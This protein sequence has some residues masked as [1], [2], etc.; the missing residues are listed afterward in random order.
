MDYT[1]EQE[2][3]FPWQVLVLAVE[4]GLLLVVSILWAVRLFKKGMK[5]KTRTKFTEV[6]KERCSTNEEQGEVIEKILLRKSKELRTARLTYNEDEI[7]RQWSL[8]R[9]L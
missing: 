6:L 2:R 5:L 4:I 7:R 1:R 3:P 8:G 9:I